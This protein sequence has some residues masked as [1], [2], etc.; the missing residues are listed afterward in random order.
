M[1]KNELFKVSPGPHVRG[2]LTMFSVMYEVILALIPA[3]VFGMGRYGT[4]ALLVLLTAVGTAMLTEYAFDCFAGRENTVRDGSAALTGL[5]LGLTLPADVELYIP[6]AG[7]VVAVTIFKGFFGG[8]GKNLLNPALG[9]R[10][11]LTVAFRE[12]MAGKD[13]AVGTAAADYLKALIAHPAGLIGCSALA[14]LAGGLFL[15]AV[16]GISWHIPVSVLVGFAVFSLLFGDGSAP[17]LYQFGGG[18]VLAAFFMATD[19]VTGPVSD[20]GKL[21]YGGLTGLL[22]ALFQKVTGPMEAMCIAVL[23]ANLTTPLIDKRFVPRP[24]TF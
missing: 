14:L 11:L 4:H 8:L 22:A 7:A 16:K 1:N 17:I 5:L 2:S 6:F 9:A 3:A 12:Q 10:C 18:V 21:I 15:L 23:L 24:Y 20:T 19:P 13:F